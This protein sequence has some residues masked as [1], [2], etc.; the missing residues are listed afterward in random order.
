MQYEIYRS[1][2]TLGGLFASEGTQQWRWRL[3]A[4]NQ[5]IIANSGESFHN[6]QDCLHSIDLVK[7]SARV[8]VVET[9]H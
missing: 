9:P 8:P 6:R 1:P 7:G 5:R 2:G 3:R 4:D